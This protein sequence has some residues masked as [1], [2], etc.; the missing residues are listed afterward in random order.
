MCYLEE[1]GGG[2]YYKTRF[3][4]VIEEFKIGDVVECINADNSSFIIG[5][6]YTITGLNDDTDI[7]VKGGSWDKRRFKLISDT[8]QSATTINDSCDTPD[9][10]FSIPIGAQYTGY[11]KNKDAIQLKILEQHKDIAVKTWQRTH[12]DGA[13]CARHNENKALIWDTTTTGGTGSF[14]CSKC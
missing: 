11:S 13:Y 1:T 2:G 4:L 9:I 6:H 3:E 10:E 8:P 12:L 14:V 5:D 7:I